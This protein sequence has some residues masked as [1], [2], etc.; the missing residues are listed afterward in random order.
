MLGFGWI[1]Y[2]AEMITRRS[3]QK[4]CK[5]CRLLYEKS[6]AY[7]PHCVDIGD[8]KLKTLLKKR[9]RLLGGLGTGM[10]VASLVI[11]LLLLTAK[12]I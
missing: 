9:K 5:R 4:L 11:T 12:F 8:S 10:L 7:C 3:R 2:V 6:F 1:R